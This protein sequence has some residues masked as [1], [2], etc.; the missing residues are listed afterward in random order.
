MGKSLQEMYALVGVGPFDA[1]LVEKEEQFRLVRNSYRK[2][3]L[4]HH[5]DKGGDP[6]QFRLLQTAFEYLR[7]HVR[8]GCSSPT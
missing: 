4:K 7:D 2:K 8:R 5:P 1:A 6:E 3:A